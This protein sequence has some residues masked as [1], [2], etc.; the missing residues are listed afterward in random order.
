MSL[1]RC[2]VLKSRMNFGLN[3]YAK[4]AAV[5]FIF[6]RVSSAS[7]FWSE[8]SFHVTRNIM[9]SLVSCSK[10]LCKAIASLRLRVGSE[11]FFFTFLFKNVSVMKDGF[12]SGVNIIWFYFDCGIWVL[13]LRER[14][15]EIKSKNLKLMNNLF[16]I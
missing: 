13:S 1:K 7:I 10:M 6:F 5:E 8:K 9:I 15:E 11:E 2:D 14:E 16:L 4:G 3:G 12:E